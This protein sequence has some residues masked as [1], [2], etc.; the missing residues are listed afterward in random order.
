MPKDL[1]AGAY[2]ALITE[3][4][5]VVLDRSSET[6]YFTDRRLLD[7][8]ESHV[9]LARHIQDLLLRCLRAFPEDTRIDRQVALCNKVLCVLQESVPD[10][11]E[12]ASES[13]PRSPHELLAFLRRAA[14]PGLKPLALARP[15]IPLAS[16]AL[17][18]NGSGE[19]TI[20][21]E[22][23]RE[24]ASA[25]RADLLCAFIR[26]HGVRML[27]E[28]IQELR[29]RGGTLRIITTT[30]MGVTE[31][32]AL[33]FLAGLGAEI[34]V[35]YETNSTRLHA[36]AWLFH[37]A[38]GYSTGF[39]GSSNL[40]HS[41][42]TSGLEWN[43]RVSAI[44]APNVF[45][46]SQAT[47]DSYWEDSS[48]V[49]YDPEE[50]QSA[51]GEAKIRSTPSFV[52]LDV[53]PYPFQQ[54]I[55]EK[56]DVERKRHQRWCNLVVAATGTG[57]TVMAALDYRRL[58]AEL[59]SA[60]LLYVAHRKEILEQSLR[61]F[62]H[63]MRDGAFG[64]L[65]VGGSQPGT[66]NH[67]FASIQS[68]T[69]RDI[70]S[71]PAAH[72]DIVVVDE[73]HHAAAPSYR[74]LLEHLTPRVLVGL[75]ATPERA[76]GLDVTEWFGGRIA[77]ELRLWEAIQRGLLCP[78]QYFG[79]HDDVDLSRLH[80]RRGGYDV[81]E[82]DGVY[83]GNDARVLKV[84]QVV[85]D[86]VGN[87]RTMRALGFC[88]SV[89]HATYMAARFVA[90][91]IPALAV[92]AETPTEERESA[93]RRL[94]SREVN[95]VFAVDLFNEGV[96]VPEIDTV[97][98]LRPT[99][100]AT[101]FLQQLGR[102]LRHAEGKACLTVLDFIG[103]QHERFRYDVR[104]RALVEPRHGGIARQVEE[105][106]PFLP[107]GC[108]VVLDRVASELILENIKRSLRLNRDELIGDLREVGETTLA[109]FLA[110]RPQWQLRDVYRRLG[111]CWD[112][113]RRE[114]GLPSLGDGPDNEALRRSLGRMLHIE[115]NER[116]TAY[117]TFLDGATPPVCAELRERERRLLNML[118]FDLWGLQSEH[119]LDSGLEA[120]WRHP[121]IRGELVELLDAL[122]Q[123]AAHLVTPLDPESDEPLWIH[124]CYSRDEALA[125]LG[126]IEP[127]NAPAMREG[128]VYVEETKTLA[129][130]VTLRKALADY[131]PTTRYRD[132]FMA[133]DLLHWESQTATAVDSRRGRLYREHGKMQVRVLLFMRLDRR[134]EHLTEPYW[135]LGPVKYVSHESEK[136]MRVIWRL[137]TP[138][139]TDLFEESLVAAG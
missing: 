76:D 90:A 22:I 6:D 31:R 26:W 63:V 116:S 5:S 105:G 110:A 107:A 130:F 43:V 53:R 25:D 104:Y 89:A 81:G 19:P 77:A 121:Q 100:S 120:L 97:L 65:Y 83:T 10:A 39:V 129:L 125:A 57:K 82:L 115:D 71:I 91:G 60:R 106:F 34:K 40:S 12:G 46:K 94:R 24:L 56:L 28:P 78:F 42:L 88:V 49:P 59:A 3:G 29:G 17:L 67:V 72:F 117:R 66:W 4:L 101:V 55:L 108:E 118:H 2:E 41:A 35:S 126:Y 7:P 14:T 92:S 102:G 47:F 45:A 114:A 51:L 23:K 69:A 54:E 62:R 113:L 124:G 58:A 127:G 13:V 30:Y 99:E 123:E 70:A 32:R 122:D 80:W 98:F 73:F 1:T 68:L 95:V 44:A 61:T 11:F 84:L 75:T 86:R 128:L 74:A 85:G 139:P 112:V 134:D 48:F 87:V 138:M 132:Y 64:E 96:D 136:P 111:R 52:A 8:E 16:S 33:D 131:S 50:F 103:R 119:T 21:S 135:F 36:K 93:L 9:I 133:P 38:T 18:T 37:R 79:V 20:G 109:G 15:Q 137:D 27:R